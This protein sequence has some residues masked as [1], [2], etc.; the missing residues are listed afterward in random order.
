LHIHEWRSISRRCP[1]AVLQVSAG[2]VQRVTPDERDLDWF[3]A[4]QRGVVP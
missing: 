2:T 3:L 1:G 4:Y